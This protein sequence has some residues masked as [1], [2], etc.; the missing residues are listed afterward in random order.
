MY[1]GILSSTIW[2]IKAVKKELEEVETQI[3][4][5]LPQFSY[6]LQTM[7]RNHFITEAALIAQVGD[8]NRFSSSDNLAKYSGI[9]VVSYSSGR[10]D[11]Q[12]ANVLGDRTL[13]LIFYDLAVRFQTM[14]DQAENR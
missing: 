14:Q 8:I 11:K 1:Y 4:A 12:L 6:K 5:I 9:S 10:T 13:H 3:K 2:Q 7:K